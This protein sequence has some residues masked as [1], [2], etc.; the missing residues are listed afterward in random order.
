MK[1]KAIFVVLLTAIFCLTTQAQAQQV[2]KFT[3]MYDANTGYT[4][5]TIYCSQ[6]VTIKVLYLTQG[7]EVVTYR[8]GYDYFTPTRSGSELR[9]ITLPAGYTTVKIT[10]DRGSL[11]DATSAELQL[12][13]IVSGNAVLGNF[14]ET[15]LKTQTIR[16]Q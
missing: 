16:Y 13:T 7:P 1:V 5:A 14:E 6:P 9:N 8:I 3:D 15:H 2:I 12:Y 4:T 11:M 10:I